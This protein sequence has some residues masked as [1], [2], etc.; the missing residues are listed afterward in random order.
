MEDGRWLGTQKGW[1]RRC[2][3]SGQNEEI[4][5]SKEFESQINKGKEKLLLRQG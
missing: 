5:N 2:N 3:F 4:Q 1:A